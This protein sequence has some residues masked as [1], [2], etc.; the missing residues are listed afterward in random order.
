M[1]ALGVHSVLFEVY[2]LGSTM[3]VLLV[4]KPAHPR[5]PRPFLSVFEQMLTLVVH[6]SFSDTKPFD[7]IA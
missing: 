2:E 1:C 3:A 5:H 4:L 7:E 6:V